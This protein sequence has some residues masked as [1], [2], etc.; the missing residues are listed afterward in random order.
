MTKRAQR[1]RSNMTDAEARIWRA[2]RR[3]QINN[4]SFRRQHPMGPFILDFYCPALRLGIEI[5][6]GQH[7]FDENR[8]SDERR[9]QWFSE[10]GI[11]IVRFWNND[12]LANTAGVLSELARVV[13]Y[14]IRGQTP[15]PT[16]PLSG[17][18]SGAVP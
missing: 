9:S 6:G 18:G 13:V 2:L 3:N 1:L 17:G 5:D 7:S 4:A 15:T 14:R 10:R 8:L 12:V 16:L 11:L